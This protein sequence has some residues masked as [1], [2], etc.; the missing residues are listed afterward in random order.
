METAERLLV[1]GVNHR[2]AT[3]ALRERL[4]TETQDPAELFAELRGAG[5]GE[6]CVLSTC[7]RIEILAVHEEPAAVQDSLAGLLA[8]RASLDAATFQTQSYRHLGPD[9]LE[10]LF[11]VT[12]SLD[13]LVVGEPQILGQVKESHRLATAAGMVGPK[14]EP[15]LQAAYGAAKRVRSETRIG[16]RP[17]TMATAALSLARQVHGD[18][19]R[20]SGLLLGL[21]EMGEALGQELRDA[22]I[23]ELMV[24]HSSLD[25]A[26]A[27]AHRLGG[28][29][30]PW[31]ELG[32]AL[33]AADIV[34]AAAG[35]GRYSIS[36]PD[37]RQALKRRRQRP[38]FLI[39]AAV[40]SDIDPAVEAVSGA[41]VYSLDDLEEVAREGVA[42]RE[43]TMRTAWDI[44]GEE[45]ARFLRQRAERSAVPAVTA[46]REH[47][48]SVRQEILANGKLD[49]EA[50]TRLLVKRLLHGPSEALREAAGRKSGEQHEMERAAARLF[51]L[52]A[53]GREQDGDDGEESK[54]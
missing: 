26:E 20:R 47:F 51:G 30:R 34:V 29:F 17:V 12:A 21:G 54:R 19:D 23:G 36:V 41:F 28:H 10:H 5:F 48:E 25:R 44:L 2:S 4:F 35:T 16:E 33:A 9:A 46:L 7:D 3:S 14:L 43:A 53:A 6:A 15:V 38:M 11:A 32:E 40:P 13:S 45:T 31:E 39:D 8:R 49:A 24:V 1:V 37:I 50:A 52:G 42:A 18:L 27:A 22:G